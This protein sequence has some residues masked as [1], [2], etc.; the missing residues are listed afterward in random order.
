MQTQEVIEG[1][2]GIAVSMGLGDPMSRFIVA[3]VATSAVAY[4]F[5][6]PRTAFRSDG[7]MR[8]YAKLSA[9][10]DATRAH[11]LLIPLTVGAIVG[12]CT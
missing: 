1:W 4:A 3:T 11:F 7:S 8:P 9:S 2:R 12:L 5:K 10:P 6:F